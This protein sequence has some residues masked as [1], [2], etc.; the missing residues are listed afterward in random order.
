MFFLFDDTSLDDSSSTNIL[1]TTFNYVIIYKKLMILYLTFERNS[2][3]FLWFHLKSIF[4][5]MQNLHIFQYVLMYF[6][7]YSLNYLF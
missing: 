4:C 1:K 6:L 5:L 7:I 2:K 3:V